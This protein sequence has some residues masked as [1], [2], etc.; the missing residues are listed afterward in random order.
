MP[1]SKVCVPVSA[2]A[3]S[4]QTSPP[5]LIWVL[6]AGGTI[7]S[8]AGEGGA[9]EAG[10]AAVLSA[11]ADALHLQVC[12]KIVYRGLSEDLTLSGAAH[13]GHLARQLAAEPETAGVVVMH[14]TDT[15]EETAFLCELFHDSPTPIV[16]TGAQYPPAAPD[17]DGLRNLRD[18]LALAAHSDARGRGVMLC[19]GGHILAAHSAIKAHSTHLEA[20]ASLTPGGAL[21]AMRDGLPVFRLPRAQL[22]HWPEVVPVEGIEIV[23]AMLGASSRVI[24]AMVE[25]G[26]PGLVLEALGRGNAPPGMV[27]AVARACAA[28]IPVLWVS[29]CAGGVAPAYASGA[30]LAAAGV[31]PGGVLDARKARLLLAVALAEPSTEMPLTH[32]IADYVAALARVAASA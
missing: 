13:I 1:V 28:D 23:P 25:A 9:L 26:A 27:Q 24:D 12:E 5:R 15:M 30:R 19:F 8:A 16:L 7:T 31:L 3:P 4:L 22:P 11:V 2:S 10:D 21:G 17:F 14:G 29:R 6:N 18:A 20:F 32:R